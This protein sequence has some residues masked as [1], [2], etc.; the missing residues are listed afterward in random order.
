MLKIELKQFDS[1]CGFQRL[2]R[3]RALKKCFYLHI[4][5]INDIVFHQL[6][7]KDQRL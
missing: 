7:I 1:E 5:Q 3:L 6:P 4:Q 2:I